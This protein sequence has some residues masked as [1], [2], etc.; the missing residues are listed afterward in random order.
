MGWTL[1]E[2]LPYSAVIVPPPAVEEQSQPFYGTERQLFMA[3]T[4][5]YAISETPAQSLVD[6]SCVSSRLP[7]VIVCLPSVQVVVPFVV[8]LE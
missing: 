7:S 5:T 4:L 1:L 8:S 2:S 6:L 3:G